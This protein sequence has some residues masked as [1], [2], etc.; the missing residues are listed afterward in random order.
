MAAQIDLGRL[1]ASQEQFDTC[2]S[3]SPTHPARHAR[4]YTRPIW[5]YIIADPLRILPRLCTVRRNKGPIGVWTYA[6]RRSGETHNSCTIARNEHFNG[7][8]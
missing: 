4:H 8:P 6:V 1:I 7:F 5:S 3:E 2:L